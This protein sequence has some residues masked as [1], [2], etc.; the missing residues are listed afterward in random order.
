[1]DQDL[2]QHLKKWNWGAFLLNWLW[3]VGNNTYS[4]FK[5][6][7]PVYGIYFLFKLGLHGNE[8]AWKNGTW[9]S[10]EHFVKVQR[11][12]SRASFAY[13]AFCFLL[14]LPMFFFVGRVFKTSEPYFSSLA[15]LEGSRAFESEVGIPY[16]TGFIT[17]SIST[18]GHQ[19]RANMAFNI[20][21]K[22][23]EAQV[24]IKA[25]KD[26][27]EWAVPCVQIKYKVSAVQENHGE[28]GN[29]S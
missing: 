13:V 23:G 8:Y 9:K 10:E 26:M 11:N 5:V 22:H 14:A 16:Q 19:G 1:M 21:G 27:G 7:I 6:F 3:G 17:G 24:L 20:E 18:S 29:G 28:C 15:L 4:A 25:V 12:W 2:P